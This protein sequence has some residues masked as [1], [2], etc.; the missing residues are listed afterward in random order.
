MLAPLKLPTENT[1]Q[2]KITK[3]LSLYKVV[4]IKYV[5]EL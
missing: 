3:D 2:T 1:V 5:Q 4:V